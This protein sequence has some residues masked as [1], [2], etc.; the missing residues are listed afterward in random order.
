MGVP[1]SFEIDIYCPANFTSINQICVFLKGTD[2]NI[3]RLKHGSYEI[4]DGKLIVKDAD[5]ISPIQLDLPISAI[6]VINHQEH[7]LSPDP[8]SLSLPSVIHLQHD[9]GDMWHL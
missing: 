9:S 8:L 4:I 6:V 5:S 7:S 2:F 3:T 1:N